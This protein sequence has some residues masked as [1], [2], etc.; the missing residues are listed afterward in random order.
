MLLGSAFALGAVPLYLALGARFG[1]EGV[2]AAGA[3]AMAANAA[4]TLAWAR[5]RH[6]GP[7]L[8]PIALAGLRALAIATPAAAAAAWCVAGRPGTVGALADLAL[9][10][11]AFAAVAGAGVALVGDVAL[12]DAL[13]RLARRLPGR[14]AAA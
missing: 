8:A 4:A 9:G 2:A 11:A 13:R 7:A 1:V 14:R 5:W 10:G 3:L 6:G 12:R